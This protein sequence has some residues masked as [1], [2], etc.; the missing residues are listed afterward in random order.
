MLY[1]TRTVNNKYTINCENIQPSSSANYSENEKAFLRRRHDHG[2]KLYLLRHITAMPIVYDSLN[3]INRIPA[4]INFDQ[5]SSESSSNDESES[6]SE[7]S[8]TERQKGFETWMKACNPTLHHDKPDQMDNGGFPEF[9]ISQE[10]PT[11][12][13]NNNKSP[14]TINKGKQKTTNHSSNHGR[15]SNEVNERMS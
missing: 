9:S 6:N 14:F 5:P 13:A 11:S 15:S 1:I 12:K 3:K 4:R 2:E 10:T 8:R 7:D